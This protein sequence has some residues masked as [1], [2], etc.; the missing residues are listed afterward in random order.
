M[1]EVLLRAVSLLKTTINVSWVPPDTET[2]NFNINGKVTQIEDEFQIDISVND[3][4]FIKE[5]IFNA[6][7]IAVTQFQGSVI[8]SELENIFYNLAQT[9]HEECNQWPECEQS[10]DK[11]LQDQDIALQIVGLKCLRELC[12]AKNHLKSLENKG[13]FVLA[14][15]YLPMLE[16]IFAAVSAD[17][18]NPHQM[19]MMVL[20][21][22]IFH[23]MNYSAVAPYLIEP[24]AIRP[25]IEFIV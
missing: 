8:V 20:V 3:R 14:A 1:Q 2:E 23:L 9:D 19:E 16:K 21:L 13:I 5:H 25:W 22:K 7:Y 6:L 12:R 18:Q 15:H 24:G 4:A 10:I 11:C 17:G